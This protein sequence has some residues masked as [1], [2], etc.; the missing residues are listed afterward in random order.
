MAACID[1][2]MNILHFNTLVFNLQL[3]MLST[4]L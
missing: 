3:S 1:E 2:E 4:L